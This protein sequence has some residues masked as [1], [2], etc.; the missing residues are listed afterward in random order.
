LIVALY[1]SQALNASQVTCSFLDKI[2]YP[3]LIR[4]FEVGQ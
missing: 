2:W 1:E 4:S 3:S